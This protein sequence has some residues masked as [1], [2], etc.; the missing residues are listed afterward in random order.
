MDHI[1]VNDPDFSDL[2]ALTGEI[3]KGTLEFIREVEEF[4]PGSGF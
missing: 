2:D 4:I 1:L 3:E